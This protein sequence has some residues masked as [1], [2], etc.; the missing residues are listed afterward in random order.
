MEIYR[1]KIHKRGTDRDI[2]SINF[3]EDIS[4]IYKP[5]IHAINSHGASHAGNFNDGYWIYYVDLSPKGIKCFNESDGWLDWY[6]VIY[7][8]VLKKVQ[9]ANYINKL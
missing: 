1:V 4:S 7:K 6:R 3:V 9:L 8:L 5:D 2:I